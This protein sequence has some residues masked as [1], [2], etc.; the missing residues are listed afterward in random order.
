[1]LLCAV[2]RKLSREVDMF[3]VALFLL[4]A[5]LALV[6]LFAQGDPVPLTVTDRVKMWL[7][8]LEQDV[9]N[10][11]EEPGTEDFQW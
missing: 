10:L 2:G 6:A 9:S 5:L 4:C 8:K 3:G 1:M 7:D 11:E